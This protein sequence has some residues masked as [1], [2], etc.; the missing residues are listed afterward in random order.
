MR[1]ALVALGLLSLAGGAFAQ[2]DV[3]AERRAAFDRAGTH[4]EAIKAMVD[5]RSD[6]RQAVPRLDEMLAWFQVMHEK[7]PEG[8]GTGNTRARPAI[9]SDNAGF[10]QAQANMVAQLQSYRA[11][12][13]SGDQE[14]FAAG[15]RQTNATC[16]ACHRVNRAR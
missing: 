1:A 11:I 12:A 2:A 3:I 7:F 5:S 8:S 16:V 13:A 10:R 14:A 4:F 6:P 15:F 9:W